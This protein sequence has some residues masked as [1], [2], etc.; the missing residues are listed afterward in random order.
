[1]SVCISIAA[2]ASSITKVPYVDGVPESVTSSTG[3]FTVTCKNLPIEDTVNVAWT[4]G[5]GTRMYTLSAT[6]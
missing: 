4:I 5:S 3:A 6:L 1:M 2:S